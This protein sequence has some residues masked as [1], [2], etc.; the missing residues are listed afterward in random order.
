MQQNDQ[1]KEG[2]KK[3]VFKSLKLL[4]NFL[5]HSEYFAGETLTIADISILANITT[6]DVS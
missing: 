4:E 3:E 6:I 1:E 2:A 5:S